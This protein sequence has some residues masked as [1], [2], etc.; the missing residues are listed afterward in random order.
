MKKFIVKI[1]IGS[2]PSEIVI[3]AMN[4]ANA[5]YIARTMFPQ[6][7]VISAKDYKSLS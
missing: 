7:R 2:S 3:P 1:W 6:A 5:L 4:S